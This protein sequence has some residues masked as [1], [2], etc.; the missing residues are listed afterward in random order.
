MAVHKDNPDIFKLKVYSPKGRNK[1]LARLKR[2]GILSYN[3]TQAVLGSKE[4]MRQR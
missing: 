3:K 4:M 2:E 1:E